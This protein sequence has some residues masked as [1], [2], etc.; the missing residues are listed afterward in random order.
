M[1]TVDILT[2]GIIALAVIAAIVVIVRNKKK[3]RGSCG[4]D[5]SRCAC[6]ACS[7]TDAA[8]PCPTGRPDNTAAMRP[9][10]ARERLKKKDET[11]Q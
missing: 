6:S 8:D 1:N 2:A 10:G 5:C 7:K 11:K 9:D 4:C 3:G